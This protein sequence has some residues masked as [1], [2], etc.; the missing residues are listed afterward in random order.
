MKPGSNSVILALAIVAAALGFWVQR[1]D[2]TPPGVT[3]AGVGDVAPDV[4][5]ITPDGK[6]RSLSGWRGRKVL[7]NFW[8][9][10]CGPCRR[11]MPLLSAAAERHADHAVVLGIAED[12][13]PPVRA[14]LAD[15][16]VAYP[17]LLANEAAPGGSLSFGNTRQVLPYSVLIGTD[18]RILRRKMGTFSEREL[19]EWLAR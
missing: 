17:V 2:D 12:T 10:W 9:T 7:L 8:A 5:W 13:A 14:W 4:T 3:L 6:P 16:P 19:D 11:E 18:G 1:H 15:R